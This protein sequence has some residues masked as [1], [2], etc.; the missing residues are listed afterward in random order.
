MVKGPSHFRVNFR[1]AIE[2]FRFLASSQT[3]S[4]LAKGE[5]P[6]LLR[7]DMTWQV[8]SCVASAS[9]RMATRDLKQDSTAGMKELE[10]KEGRVQDSY[11]IMR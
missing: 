6:Q 8:S 1:L 4:S 9:S 3:L 2:C 7:E 10:I 5:N 11:P